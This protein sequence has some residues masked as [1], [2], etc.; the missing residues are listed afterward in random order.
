L[1]VSVF[2]LQGVETEPWDAFQQRRRDLAARRPEGAIVLFG[3]SEMQGR[4]GP[5]PLVQESNFYYLSGCREPDAALLIEP[6]T[7]DR[8]YRETLFLAKPD[9]VEQE[10][11]GRRIDPS[12]ETAA[13]ET[14][15]AE[16]LESGDLEVRLRSA[17]KRHGRVYAL[18]GDGPGVYGR[19][20]GP[21]TKERLAELGVGAEPYN[22]RGALA[23]MRLVKS[24][25]E[26]RWIERAVAASVAAHLAAWKALRPGIPEYA[27]FGEMSR[28]MIQLGALRPAYPPIVASGPNATTL[29]YV[30]LTRTIEPGE[31]VLMDVGAEA[32][33]YAAD[34]TRTVPAD[35]RFSERQREVYEWV[36]EARR[37]AIA[38]ARPGA[39]LSGP[40][41]LTE[42]VERFYDSKQPGLSK[43]LRHAV[44]HFVGLD[45]H[46]PNP[47][48]TPLAEGMV[49]TIEP[50][51]YLADEGLGVRVEDMLLITKDG[52]RLLSAGLPSEVDAIEAAL[53]DR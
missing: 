30:D 23:E 7:E 10:W 29:H 37:L 52:A 36:L 28:A 20:A 43:R 15:F 38:A 53:A 42:L 17:V 49:I 19:A 2:T 21:Q 1:A 27:L 40:G 16:V 51:L 39:R 44:G 50:G 45:V 11:N 31:L 4:L 9:G 48:S 33:G 41:S 26:V 6:A 18:L 5:G 46:D 24:E 3:V 47:L 32:G 25:T 8:R 12:R 35:G 14:G 13:S 34:L 22:V